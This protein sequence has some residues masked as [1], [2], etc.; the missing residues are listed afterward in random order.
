MSDFLLGNLIGFIAPLFLRANLSAA[1]P[2]SR[3]SNR[4][5][6]AGVGVFLF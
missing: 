6:L 3:G 5:G 2:G 1:A 4:H